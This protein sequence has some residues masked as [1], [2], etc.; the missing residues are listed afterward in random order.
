MSDFP[1]NN[2]PSFGREF[3][4]FKNTGNIG[5]IIDSLYVQH[6]DNGFA[7]FQYTTTTETENK[8]KHVDIRQPQ[9]RPS[10]IK[11]R[12]KATTNQLHDFSSIQRS[13]GKDRKRDNTELP[14]NL[15][16]HGTGY[17]HQFQLA[18]GDS[19]FFHTR[20]QP[21]LI[22]ADFSRVNIKCNDAYNPEQMITLSGEGIPL[23]VTNNPSEIEVSNVISADTLWS[24][25][26]IEIQANVEI[27]S[28]ARLTIRPHKDTISVKA[29]SNSG[30]IVLGELQARRSLN[31]I[32]GISFAGIDSLASWKGF[33][34]KDNSVGESRLDSL[35]IVNTNDF[36]RLENG[37]GAI[38]ISAYHHLALN[39]VEI[40][41]SSSAMNGGAILLEQTE[42]Q[43][44]DCSITDS[45]AQNGGAI[46]VVGNDATLRI[47]GS[48]LIDNEA[49]ESG[50]SLYIDQAQVFITES[51]IAGSH[52]SI[53]G[54]ISASGTNSYLSINESLF[55]GNTSE[56][57]GGAIHLDSGK[58]G[59]LGSSFVQNISEHG[60]AIAVFGDQSN[61]TISQGI[62][63]ENGD[64]A[65]ASS[66][67][68]NG[69]AI[70]HA[71][72]ELTISGG[73]HFTQNRGHTGGAI[74]ITDDTASLSVNNALFYLNMA[75][76]QGGAVSS[77][78]GT[79]KIE[80]SSFDGCFAPVYGGA[81][82]IFDTDYSLSR[83][84]FTGCL[85][86]IDNGKGGS[87]FIDNSNKQPGKKVGGKANLINLLQAN[88]IKNSQAFAG[89]A[90]YQHGTGDIVSNAIVQ[91]LAAQGGGFYLKHNTGKFENNTIADN[92]AISFGGAIVCDS[93]GM[94]IKNTIIWGNEQANGNPVYCIGVQN[95][96]FFNCATED[97]YQL[98]SGVLLSSSIQDC[99]SEDPVFDLNSQYPYQLYKTSLCVNGG[100][101]ESDI[102]G[103]DVLGNPRINTNN[104]TPIIDI[105]AYE[106]MGAYW[107]CTQDTISGIVRITYSPT[108]F[109]NDL[110]VK[111][112]ST[113][114][115]D[116]GISFLAANNSM[117]KVFGSIEAQG[118]KTSP[119]NFS[120]APGN[121]SWYGFSFEGGQSAGSSIFEYCSFSNGKAFPDATHTEP[122]ASNGGMMYIDDYSDITIDH[123]SFNNNQARDNGGAIYITTIPDQDTLVISNS[124]FVSN[125]VKRSTGGAICAIDCNLNVNGNAFSL[126]SA[127]YPLDLSVLADAYGFSGGALSLISTGSIDIAYAVVGNQFHANS[128]A[129]SGGSIFANYGTQQIN[130]NQFYDSTALGANKSGIIEC[131]YGGG[132]ISL[133]NNAI[134]E[135]GQNNFISNKA[136]AGGAIL[137]SGSTCKVSDNTFTGNKANYGGAIQLIDL[138]SENILTKN[139]FETNGTVDTTSCFIGG[140]IRLSDSASRTLISLNKFSE[141]S[142]TSMGGAI[143]IQ[144]SD[145]TIVVNNQI[146]HNTSMFGGGVYLER[147]DLEFNNNTIVHNEGSAAGGGIYV[148]GST[149]ESTNN[150]HWANSAPNGFEAYLTDNASMPAQYCFISQIPNAIAYLNGATATL[151]GCLGETGV[152]PQLINNIYNYNLKHDSPCVNR[153][154]HQVYCTEIDLNARNRI[155]GGRIDIGAYE[156][157]GTVIDSSPGD[158]LTIWNDTCISVV[159]PI[160]ISQGQKLL[161]KDNVTVFFE[162][163]G[164]LLVQD[165]E[166]EIL[167]NVSFVSETAGTSYQIVLKEAMPLVLNNI[168]AFGVKMKSEGTFLNI[169]GSTFAN[170]HLTHRNQSLNILDTEFASSNLDL[171]NTLVTND[172]LGVFIIDSYFH[173]QAD[174]TAIR[175]YSYPNYRINNN[176]ISNYYNGLSLFESGHGNTFSL[177]GNQI[178]GN[179]YGYGIQVYH[180]NLDIE[181]NGNISNN[182]I[183]LGALRNSSLS[184]IGNNEPPY[185]SINNNYWD[186]LAFT[187]DSFP[188]DI[189]FNLIYDSIHPSDV[190]IRCSGCNAPEIHDLSYN[191]W[192]IVEPD[193]YFFPEGKYSHLPVWEMDLAFVPDISADYDLFAL[194]KYNLKIGHNDLAAIH[195][196]DLISN[197]P[198]TKYK[199][200]AAKLL[201][202]AEATCSDKIYDLKHFYATEPNL[203]NEMGIDILSH[204]LINYCNLK[205][206]DYPA[207][208]DW[209]E[210]IIDNPPSVADSIYAVIDLAYTYLLMNETNT[211]SQYHGKY[212]HYKPESLQSFRRKLDQYI[213]LLLYPSPTELYEPPTP[214]PFALFQNYPNPF[215][216]STTIQYSLPKAAKLRL[217]IYN[218]KGQLVKTLVNSEMPAGTHSVVWNGRDMKN[219]AVASGVY[220]YRISSPKEGSITKKMMLMK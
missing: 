187:Y 148:N 189:K 129:G 107:V 152:S 192:S 114:H 198:D 87:V 81:I 74:S 181:S 53:G 6:S 199:E 56:N 133:H 18:P 31:Q 217:D 160:T 158:T 23:V 202:A 38:H 99:L 209:Y 92:E 65:E 40:K 201:M 176:V 213:D 156:Y 42:V 154:T 96:D 16:W 58:L 200:E 30:F 150:L 54:G 12:A 112:E 162:P 205:L 151:Y 14:K 167:N 139:V 88:E 184:M 83:N 136:H 95:L 186:E 175:I 69:G 130:S 146:D 170:S 1:A 24:C 132:A 180:S 46:A 52:A 3:L 117:I 27:D 111:N 47:T 118:N 161:I 149:L 206:E 131:N 15:T 8:Y 177:A 145:S 28:Q 153:G 119:I 101:K 126:N 208:I 138:H 115:I 75:S 212:L 134:A 13:E 182:Y 63:N 185:Q 72:G 29:D 11:A 140:A 9:D 197:Y 220:F 60:G 10:N 59:V 79:L 218:I 127:N 104:G 105:G 165:A 147:A 171:L 155:V 70:Y 57:Y 48:S 191:Y 125:R 128:A 163:Y 190:L 173:D 216:P 85:S 179:Q 121:N 98:S 143:A 210:G 76:V 33:V 43:V 22:G 49:V 122:I 66:Y 204:Y 71:G 178:Q 109:I 106:F 94:E 55:T 113:L 35:L 26:Q 142:C 50:G 32:F 211:R 144:A 135:I 91:N 137:N 21:F 39:S 64:L 80:N 44:F 100:T 89:G 90:I 215:N 77:V 97:A 124:S 157:S 159:A 4:V 166:L 62:F 169:L 67:S 123:C 86:D 203:H 172:T 141:N 73:T 34:F 2:T 214:Q 188:K 36:G 195:F 219:R 102:E 78:A 82:A 196:R 183:G 207:V 193:K 19:V 20:Y 68:C 116:S 110:E 108:H 174:S 45:N 103:M 51:Q 84:L 17:N 194:A 93:L 61:V 5:L 164:A 168:T 37:G 25:P 120:T 41:N 7:I